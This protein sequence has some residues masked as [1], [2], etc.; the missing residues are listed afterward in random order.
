MSSHNEFVVYNTYRVIPEYVLE[1]T[2]SGA[3]GTR[4]RSRPRMKAAHKH[5]STLAHAHFV[6]QQAVQQVR[7]VG[8][9]GLP[10]FTLPSLPAASAGIAVVPSVG[11]ANAA[12]PR[13]LHPST[14]SVS[15]APLPIPPGNCQLCWKDPASCKC[16]LN[17]K[18]QCKYCRNLPTKCTCPT[19][20]RASGEEIPYRCLAPINQ[21][22][23][24]WQQRNRAGAAASSRS[25]GA[26]SSNR[27]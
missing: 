4:A 15:A 21:G 5:T 1:Y 24:R 23:V 8:G 14:G 10:N 12:P 6:V 17:S 27:K 18:K 13:A 2:Y 3:A 20:K 22:L 26:G 11:T 25:S 16:G 19:Y 9:Y 7:R